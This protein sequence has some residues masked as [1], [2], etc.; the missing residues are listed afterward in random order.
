MW[1]FLSASSW[2]LGCTSWEHI[3]FMLATERPD[4]MCP[5]CEQLQNG[6]ISYKDPLIWVPAH[7]RMKVCVQF[8]NNLASKLDWIASRRSASG[9]TEGFSQFLGKESVLSG[10]DSTEILAQAWILD[11]LCSYF[12]FMNVVCMWIWSEFCVCVHVYVSTNKLQSW[13]AEEKEEGLSYWYS[14]LLESCNFVGFVLVCVSGHVTAMYIL[15]VLSLWNV[16]SVLP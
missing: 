9:N 2:R 15:C 1:E 5:V 10:M 4:L 13:W 7:G 3:V 11:I 14:Y 12:R 6:I 8:S 16:C